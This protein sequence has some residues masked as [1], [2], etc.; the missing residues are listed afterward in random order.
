M[1]V[2]ATFLAWIRELRQEINTVYYAD[3]NQMVDFCRHHKGAVL[4]TDASIR[5]WYDARIDAAAPVTIVNAFAVVTADAPSGQRAVLQDCTDHQ[6]YPAGT[7]FKE[8][9]ARVEGPRATAAARG[10][11]LKAMIE[12]AVNRI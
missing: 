5:V 3:T 10:I 6:K 9:D 11:A 12:D 4:T 8:D 1:R 7:T 2:L